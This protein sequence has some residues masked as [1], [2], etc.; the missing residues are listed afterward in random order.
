[1]SELTQPQLLALRRIAEASD[2]LLVARREHK[3]AREEAA[4]ANEIF[5]TFKQAAVAAKGEK[6]EAQQTLRDEINNAPPM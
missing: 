6:D 1:M 5:Q 4:Q 3:K 2:H